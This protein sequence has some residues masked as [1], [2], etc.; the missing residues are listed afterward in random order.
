MIR[1][2]IPFIVLLL[3][4][5]QYLRPEEDR[6]EEP[7]VDLVFY[8]KT[9]KELEDRLNADPSNLKLIELQLSYYERLGWPDEALNAVNRAQKSLKNDPIL[10]RKMADFYYVNSHYDALNNLVEDF[11]S[12]FLL[13]NWAEK[14]RIE[15]L[16]GTGKY[17]QATNMLRRY[18]ASNVEEDNEW[19][20]YQYLALKDSLLALYHF[21]K[22]AKSDYPLISNG[23]YLSL[24]FSNG[25]YVEVINTLEDRPDSVE[26]S[27][28]VAY[29]KAISLDN[30]N[31]RSEAKAVL[32]QQMDRLAI[33]Q[34]SDWYAEENKW[35]SSHL[36]L[37]RILMDEPND[38]AA[39]WAKAEIDERRGWLSMS[40]N[41]FNS[42]KQIDSTYLDVTNRV[43]ILNR[44]IAYL[45]KIRGAQEQRP[46]MNLESK[47][48]SRINE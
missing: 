34:L 6:I 4:S 39:L 36:L 29:M 25:L 46:V 23:T 41:S 37:N 45:R 30:M 20:A 31:R 12:T 42:I 5:C 10:I 38:L 27:H 7:K 26:V 1:L 28:E 33:F 19:G 24:L 21:N 22:A 40:L 32:L 14:Y 44:K 47:K 13:P 43:D 18:L 9:V 3:S 2:Y 16:I 35:D 11:A 8:R 48:N 15:S 17:D